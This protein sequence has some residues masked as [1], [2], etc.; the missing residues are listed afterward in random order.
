MKDVKIEQVPTE[1][2]IINP[3]TKLLSQ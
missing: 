2:N 1:K 3:L